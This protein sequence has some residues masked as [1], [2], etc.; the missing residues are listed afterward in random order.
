MLIFFVVSLSA[1]DCLT[2]ARRPFHESLTFR[3][4]CETLDG[5]QD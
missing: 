1:P 5:A 2:K 4:N 3:Y